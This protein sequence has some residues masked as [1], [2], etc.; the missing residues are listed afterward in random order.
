MD[1]SLRVGQGKRLARR[2]EV[3][4]RV[5]FDR[6]CPRAHV[7]LPVAIQPR[8]GGAKVGV[9][10]VVGRGDGTEVIRHVEIGQ[11]MI[12]ASYHENTGVTS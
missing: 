7:V 8:R 9:W 11:D 1:V 3:L 12:R 6:P 5:T 10:G 4:S 2:W